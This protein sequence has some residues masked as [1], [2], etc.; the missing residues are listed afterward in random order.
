[1]SRGDPHVE[2]ENLSVEYRRDG[3]WHNVIRDLSLAIHP[4]EA[5]GLAGESGCGKSTLASL[6]LGEDL[7]ER[8]IT[9]GQVRFDGR[10]LHALPGRELRRLRG[11]RIG[12]VPQS[13]GTTLTPTRRIG[14]LFEDMLRH[15]RPDLPSRERVAVA[16][17]QLA[18]VGLPDPVGALGRFP[19]QF[20]GG[21]QQR[22]ALALAMSCEPDL[23]VLDEP[24]TGQDA[25]IRRGLIGL[26]RELRREAGV[27]M[28]YVSHDL[29]TLSEVC[30]RIAVMYAGEIVEVG[31]I[32]EVLGDPRHPYTRGLVAALPRLEA[33]P[34]PAAVLRGTLDRRHLPEGCRFAPRCPY[35]EAGCASRR[36][37]LRSVA[38]GHAV[39]CRRWP[40]IAQRGA[41]P[42]PFEGAEA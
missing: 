30:D 40:D 34:D 22:I 27:S 32:D 20:S 33:A 28:L 37:E 38:P 21:Q 15:H 26:F 3:A 35:A 14:R 18:R 5:V 42:L 16:E 25:L 12:M 7:S 41:A 39:A 1:M 19:H 17:A 29:A 31:P 13:G 10:D 11:A 23:I 6:L 36:Q 2:F 8:R 4:G 24:T 9:G